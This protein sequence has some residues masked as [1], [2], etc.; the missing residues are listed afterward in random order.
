M[1]DK[2]DD[3]R[4][5]QIA[6]ARYAFS[7]QFTEGKA[8]LDIACG[9]GYGS[10]YI[11]HMG[12][13]LVVGGDIWREAVEY[14]SN[15]YGRDGAHFMLADG[16]HLPF[17]DGCFD[18]VD[19]FETIRY[20]TD[21]SLFLS[22]C[23]RVLRPGGIMVCSTPNRSTTSGESHEELVSWAGREFN[24]EEFRQVMRLHFADVQLYGLNRV[25]QDKA[26][27]NPLLSWTGRAAVSLS[28]V[29]GVLG[30]M[31]FVGGLL[32]PHYRMVR[33]QSVKDWERMMDPKLKPYLLRGGAN[34]G[35]C[36]VATGRK[37][38]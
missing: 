24:G 22:E 17:A 25:D 14:A 19:S 5:W 37:S 9:G 3:W 2:L 35:T 13:R 29:P 28:H 18:V 4:S 31:N 20:M 10:R 34:S 7:S 1:P 8:V 36:L 23:L 11:R 16:C 33:L 27:S 15:S 12:A 6:L 21:P 30:A 32:S 38:N 26:G